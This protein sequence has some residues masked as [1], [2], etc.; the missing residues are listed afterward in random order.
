MGY[1]IKEYR[2]KRNM[3]QEELAELSG[4]SRA[5]ISKLETKDNAKA[6]TDTLCKLAA[7][8]NVSISEIFLG[9]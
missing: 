7:A 1:R 9:V 8:L 2:V 3:S 6:T 4:V 5:T